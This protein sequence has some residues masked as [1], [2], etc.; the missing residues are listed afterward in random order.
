MG[1]TE[2]CS[3]K[4]HRMDSISQPSNSGVFGVREL[5]R[6]FVCRLMSA[7]ITRRI[8]LHSRETK[9]ILC[10]MVPHAKTV[11]SV[12]DSIYFVHT[13]VVRVA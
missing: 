10:H 9:G 8:P 5:V 3:L 13:L 7:S 11:E 12:N 1:S 2:L 4:V 6:V